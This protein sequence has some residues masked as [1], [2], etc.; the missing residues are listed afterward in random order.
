M[1]KNC[2]QSSCV[3]IGLALL[4]MGASQTLLASECDYYKEGVEYYEQLRRAGG[5][6]EEMNFW[7]AKGH[8][9][10]DKL[11]HC[12]QDSEKSP[13]IQTTSG[14]EPAPT[15]TTVG[16]RENTPL[17]RS[18]SKDPQ[19]QRLMETCNYWIKQSNEKPSQDNNNFRDSACRALDNYQNQ[20]ETSAAPNSTN[21]IRKLKDCVKANNLIDQEVNECLKGNIEPTWKK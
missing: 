13:T 11:Y 19:T 6:A 17:R 18:F 2:H 15:S 9:L 1:L 21:H 12:K 3:S 5:N 7:T 10:E 20:P 14:D 8:E 4:L 16:K